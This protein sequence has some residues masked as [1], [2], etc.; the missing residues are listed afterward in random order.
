MIKAYEIAL[1]GS[2]LLGVAP[3][4]AELGPRERQCI[5]G[6]Q[7]INGVCR[8]LSEGAGTRAGDQGSTGNRGDAGRSGAGR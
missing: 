6:E 8:A 7:R 5:V 4:F 2:L 3:A 1:A